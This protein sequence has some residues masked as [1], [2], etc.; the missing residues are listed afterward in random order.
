MGKW[1]QL[2]KEIAPSV[3]RVTVIFNPDTAFAAPFNRAIQA[4]VPSFG[5]T[6]TLAP[7]RDDAAI[8]G[9]IAA[10]ARERGGGLLCLPDSFNTRHRD[11]IIATATRHRMPLMGQSGS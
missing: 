6:V 3:T 8:E 2:F 5:V 1:L 9:A 10:Q 4:A 7:V 11:V